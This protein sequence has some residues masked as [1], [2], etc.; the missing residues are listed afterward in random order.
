LKHTIV[1]EEY[2]QTQR[3]TFLSFWFA[4]LLV[5][6]HLLIEQ[7]RR[8]MH[9]TNKSEREPNL[10]RD[11]ILKALSSMFYT[12]REMAR[13]EL[14]DV[15]L[16][17]INQE[18]HFFGLHRTVAHGDDRLTKFIENSITVA[19][20]DECKRDIG[21]NLKVAQRIWQSGVVLEP[22]AHFEEVTFQSVFSIVLRFMTAWVPIELFP[23]GYQQIITDEFLHD[24]PHMVCRE[25][26]TSLMKDLLNEKTRCWCT[27]RGLMFGFTGGL[28]SCRRL[29]THKDFT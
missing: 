8:R 27:S 20:M 24:Y 10:R 19:V 16:L 28:S 6:F 23:C 18:E 7:K 29:A 4:I 15:A 12:D 13:N 26:I 3:T 1:V 9:G 2:S 14:L 25:E 21:I 5:H 11:Q 22:D 17:G